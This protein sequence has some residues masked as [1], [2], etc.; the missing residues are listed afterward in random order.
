MNYSA[1]LVACT[2]TRYN[3]S[4][5]VARCE[6]LSSTDKRLR[7]KH[8][9]GFGIPVHHPRDSTTWVASEPRVNNRLTARGRIRSNNFTTSQILFRRTTRECQYMLPAKA[10][11]KISQQ[12]NCKMNA[13]KPAVR[14][15]LYAHPKRNC[16]NKNNR[17]TY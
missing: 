13:K 12:K 11:K 8:A 5:L 6:P 7:I 2:K 4:W 16:K 9:L 3:I 10:T 15:D 14:I 1:R 17:V